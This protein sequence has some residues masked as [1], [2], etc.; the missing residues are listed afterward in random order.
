MASLIG[1]IFILVGLAIRYYIGRTKFNRRNNFGKEVFQS[2]EMLWIVSI[3]N[4]LGKLGST[5]LI[6]IGIA[7]MIYN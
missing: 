2:Y 6:I 3:A 4:S 5:I 1:W 7:V